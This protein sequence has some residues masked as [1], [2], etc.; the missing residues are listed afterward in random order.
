MGQ[1]KVAITWMMHARP[2]YERAA[3]DVAVRVEPRLRIVAIAIR[4]KAGIRRES[5]RHPLP[6][7]VAPVDQ[8]ESGR[9]LPF[10]FGGK[11]STRPAA[12][13]FGLKRADVTHRLVGR[14]TLP[15]C[16][17]AMLPTVVSFAPSCWMG[18]APAGKP[19]L[20]FVR[21]PLR[22]AIAASVD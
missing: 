7:G 6:H 22:V 16:K 9:A 18:Q 3:T 1:I 20:T 2:G 14:Q 8:T 4:R 17:P 19:R 15:A 21:P 13:R 12:I 5:V 10:R 11:A